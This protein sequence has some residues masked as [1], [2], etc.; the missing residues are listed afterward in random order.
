MKKTDIFIRDE[1][2]IIVLSPATKRGEAWVD[3]NIQAE[4]WQWLGGGLCVDHRMAQDIIDGMT[5][6]GLALAQG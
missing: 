4:P 6:D 1:G 2:T 5:T 3:S